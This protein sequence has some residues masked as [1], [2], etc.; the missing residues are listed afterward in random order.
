MKPE[1]WKRVDALLSAVLE[2]KEEHRAAFLAQQCEGDEELRGQVEALLKAYGAASDF[3]ETP[4]GGATE[5]LAQNVSVAPTQ[6]ARVSQIARRPTLVGRV[7]SHYRLDEPLAVGGMGVVYR[8]TDLKL[9]RPVAIKLIS[10]H[11][12]T[13]ET[14]KA[15]FVRE[16]RTASSLDH[17]NIGVIHEIGEE[18]G[19]LFIV[20]SLYEGE[21]LKQTL[22]RGA[23]PL[24]EGIRV[25]RELAL[26]LEA[27]HRAGII[28]RDI[29]PANVMLTKEGNV[30]IL[31]FGLAKLASAGAE[32]T[33]TQTGQAIGTLLYMSP[34]QLKGEAVDARSDLWSLGVLAYQLVTGVC[35]FKADSNAATVARILHDEPSP[36]AAIPGSPHWLADLVWDLLRKDPS[37]RPQTATEVLQRLEQR[38]ATR[39]RSVRSRFRWRRRLGLALGVLLLAALLAPAAWLAL[40]NRSGE[41]IE[42]LAVLPFVNGGNDPEAQYLSD[43]LTETL[44]NHL[45]QLPNLRVIARTSVSRYRGQPFDLERVSRELA[46]R[47]VLVG[48]LEASSNGFSVSAELIDTRDN[49]HLWGDNYRSKSA[50]LLSLQ[51]EISR[52]ILESVRPHLSRKQKER[53]AKR[54]TVDPQAYQLYLR[55]LYHREKW[56]AEGMKVARDY[57]QQAIKRDPN[58]ALAQVALAGTYRYPDLPRDQAIQ[59]AKEATLQALKIDETLGEAHASLAEVKLRADWDWVGAEKEYKLALELAPGYA[60]GHHLYSHYLLAASR[61]GESLIES[62][63]ALALDPLSPPMN[64]HLGYH[65]YFIREYDRAIAQYRK[66]IEMFPDYAEGHRQLGWAYVATGSYEQGVA[67]YE[68]ANALSGVSQETISAL[69]KAF[70]ASGIRG[71]WRRE[72]ESALEQSKHGYVDPIPIAQRFAN[73]GETDQAFAWLQRAYDERSVDLIELNNYSDFEMMHSDPRYQVL[74]RRIGIPAPR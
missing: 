40:R 63:R 48:T 57:Y 66:A 49:S 70:A 62:Q 11:L 3:L 39:K 22:E 34:E 27:A 6:P 52:K 17:P 15:R 10:H 31:D 42:S 5:A 19:D 64:V 44:I 25:M 55:G 30:K 12:A 69:R 9:G 33:L 1:R 35:P 67:E 45:S 16:A 8:A 72:L 58:F 53:L 46:V 61:F 24:D 41:A 59:K 21:T 54:S 14:A 38:R 26:G 74:V 56:T 4:P 20:M 50:D 65:Y 7:L 60:E 43:G 28:H 23:L 13:D 73:L 18:D 32:E 71:Y 2:R 47:A 68:K 29:K 51:G 37:E 36:L